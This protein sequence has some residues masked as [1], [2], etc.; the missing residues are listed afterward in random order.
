MKLLRQSI[1]VPLVALLVVVVICIPILISGCGEDDENPLEP[2]PIPTMLK[3]RRTGVLDLSTSNLEPND[4]KVITFS[5]ES[6]LDQEGNFSILASEA[7]KPQLMFFNSQATD[8]PVYIGLYDPLTQK[9]EADERSTALGLTLINPY[10]I[11][12]HAEQRQEYLQAVRQN[13]RFEELVSLLQDAYQT[14]PTTALDY[15]SNPIVFQ[16]VVQLMKEA[17][18]SLSVQAAPRRSALS[19]GDPPYIEDANG[20]DI[21]LV[22]PRHVFYTAG[23]YPNAGTQLQDIVTLSRK[24]QLWEYQ[25]GWP[26][27]T[28]TE[29]VETTY[30]LGDGYFHLYVTRGFDFSNFRTFF[31]P[32]TPDGLATILNTGQTLLY[33]IDIVIG[34]LPAPPLTSLPAHL[35]ISATDVRNL[36]ISL[37]KGD[38]EGFIIAFCDLF[39]KNS[40]GIA[41]W[42]WQETG[43]AGA[44]KF[45]KSAAS[46]LKNVAIVLKLLS[47][48]NE[49]GPFIWDFI[50]APRTA[51]YYVTQQNGQITDTE[52]NRSPHVEFTFDP[53]AGIVDTVFRFDASAT[54]D[55]RDDVDELEFRWD[56]ESDGTWDTG[57]QKKPSATH[58]YKEGG[59]YEVTLEVRDT[60][61]LIGTITRIVSVGGGA[62]TATH[63]KL[64]RDDLPWDSNAMIVALEEFG[65]TEGKGAHTYEIIDSTRMDTAPLIPGEDLVIISNDQDQDY[66]N[67]YAASQIRFRNFVHTGGSMFFGA[68]DRGWADGSI[69]EAEIILP[70]NITITDEA[71]RTNF[72]VQFGFPLVDGLPKT[73]DGYYASHENFTNLPDGTIVYCQDTTERATLIEFNLGGGWMIVTGQPLEWGYDRRDEYS[74][75]LLLP[76]V[77]SHFTGR[78]IPAAPA[79][80]SPVHRNK[81]TLSNK[82][83]H[84][85]ADDI[86]STTWG[87]VKSR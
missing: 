67:N 60:R 63:I 80:I 11:F 42:I 2:E 49:Q 24:E 35:D 86:F 13:P 17:M 10:L 15:E 52:E 69:T 5:E 51:S 3:E 9:T 23:V 16:M 68:C 71:D 32:R 28:W 25:W 37:A 87:E 36:S 12:T 76:R 74:I 19:V 61:G 75:G 7:D 46:L 33:L 66:Y 38:A 20:D 56:W 14:E 82:P 21:V 8:N 70:G 45:V 73:L 83:S 48:V 34:K 26:P 30:S 41:Y 57:W 65:F 59:S 85:S 44:H 27:V 43:N 54:V 4:L 1:V 84:I 6:D 72:V 53:P 62:G 29:P 18:E 64:F 55:D 40:E 39:V 81:Q 77:I 22:N 47:L 58:R 31:D 50:L 79:A 78:D